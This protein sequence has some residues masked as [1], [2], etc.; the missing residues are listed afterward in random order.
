M[1]LYNAAFNEP[2]VLIKPLPLVLGVVGLLK[3][4]AFFTCF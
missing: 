3:F 2:S 1:E 4:E